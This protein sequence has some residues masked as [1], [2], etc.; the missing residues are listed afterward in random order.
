MS[1]TYISAGLRRL[2][3]ERGLIW[4]FSKTVMT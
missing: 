1:L 4:I 2:V 3:I